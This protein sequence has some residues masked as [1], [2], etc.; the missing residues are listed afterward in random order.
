MDAITYYHIIYNYFKRLIRP[1]YHIYV[2]LSKFSMDF[3]CEKLFMA[4]QSA[5]TFSD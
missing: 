1:K 3:L 5:E 2:L 4:V